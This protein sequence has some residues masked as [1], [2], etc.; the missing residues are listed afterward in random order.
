MYLFFDHVVHVSTRQTMCTGA[1]QLMRRLPA[2]GWLLFH[3][4]GSFFA[5]SFSSCYTRAIALQSMWEL[6]ATAVAG[7][8]AG[9]GLQAALAGAPSASS[10]TTAFA[11]FAGRSRMLGLLL[12][13]VATS[14]SLT[15]Y[16]GGDWVLEDA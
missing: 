16:Y 3:K 12:S 4:P 15:A 2:S 13:T 8:N 6:V 5:L 14:S 9:A 11:R 7:L 1:E 10:D